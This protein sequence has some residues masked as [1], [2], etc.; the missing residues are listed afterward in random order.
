MAMVVAIVVGAVA[1]VHSERSTIAAGIHHI[2]GLNW[3]WAIAASLTELVSMF[4]FTQLQK[5]LLRANEFQPPLSRLLVIG[6]TSNAI[7]VFMPIVG[8]GI[9]TQHV[10]RGLRKSGVDGVVA[11]FVLT[12]AGILSAVALAAVVMMG[13]VLSG[14]PTTAVGGLLTALASIGVAAA[15][16]DQLRSEDG[17]QRLLRLCVLGIRTSQ[18][19]SGRPRGNAE[20]LANSTLDSLE[21]LRLGRITLARGLFWSV[22]N[23]VADV[24]CLAFAARSVGISTL[25]VGVTILVWTAGAGASSLS[26]TPAGIGIT[27]I[28]LVAAFAAAGFRGPSVIAAVLIYRIISLKGAV[29]VWAFVYQWLHRDP[30]SDELARPKAL[31]G[32]SDT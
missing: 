8:P 28:A 31:T 20:A 1:A 26:P 22:V 18:R 16:A 27:E 21:H 14:N 2:T 32:D 17:R 25:G 5:V 13:A 11:S 4:A 3:A 23:W 29:S 6:L 9:G 7:A 15:V 24:A 30:Y 10:Y 19:V 12:M